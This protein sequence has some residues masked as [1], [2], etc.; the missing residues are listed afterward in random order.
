MKIF[1][2]ALGFVFLSI[3]I[4]SFILSEVNAQPQVKWMKRCSYE[5]GYDNCVVDMIL[6]VDG[7]SY[8]T[9][10]IKYSSIRQD[11]ITLKY[12]KEGKLI[13][14]KTYSG[15]D[16][17]VNTPVIISLD[18][19][20][21]VIVTASQRRTAK[22]I[23]DY[24]TIKYNNNGDTLWT[25]RFNSL[26]DTSIAPPYAIPRGLA[27]DNFRNIYITGVC[28]MGPANFVTGTIKYDEFGNLKWVNYEYK[29]GFTIAVDKSNNVFV[30]SGYNSKGIIYILDSNG[31][32]TVFANDTLFSIE[33]IFIDK[34][35]NVFL[36]GIHTYYNAMEDLEFVKYDSSGN[37]KWLKIFNLPSDNPR[38]L[39]VD[40]VVDSLENTLLL[41]KSGHSG[42]A[43]WD[44]VT[45]KYNTN[46]DSVWGKI[47]NSFTGCDDEPKSIDIDK[48]GNVLVT[49]RSTNPSFLGYRMTTV[50]YDKNG[51]QK[52][53]LIYD[54]NLPYSTHEGK[55]VKVDKEG[56]FI[57]TGNSM[58][59]NGKFEIA[60]IKYSSIIGIRT[61]SNEIPD[62]FK[63]FQNY[64]NPFNSITKIK[65]QIKAG[66]GSQE[67]EIRM[68]IYDVLGKKIVI[69]IN[70]KQKA[71]IYEVMFDGSNL[72]SGI[73]FYRLTVNGSIIDTKKIILLK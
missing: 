34:N 27:I 56:D 68:I 1:F 20:G 14:I 60:T 24:F 48:S 23:F 5:S 50:I 33:K 40:F 10:Y 65:Y 17:N 29:G 16:T 25:K 59:D 45:L 53:V 8:L 37:R 30:A 18:N 13:W 67:S 42:Q 47:F 61:I 49:G 39:F 6:D 70:E 64:P 12:N 38:D 46:G 43:G 26:S 11:L 19:L 31:N 4:I 62:E 2:I 57:I 58:S 7:N 66:I 35:N 72:S 21:N 69:P 28:Y 3:T 55:K 36:G 63:L 32:K 22:Y 52:Y 41:G 9:G 51:Q 73:Y 71:G 44:Y 15:G 54:N